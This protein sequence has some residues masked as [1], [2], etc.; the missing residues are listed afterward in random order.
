[1]PDGN[2]N[3]TEKQTCTD[4]AFLLKCVL[5]VNKE[6]QRRNYPLIEPIKFE[7]FEFI[8]YAIIATEEHEH[9]TQKLLIFDL[10]N[11]NI[12]YKI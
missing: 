12:K 2:N 5:E 6:Y 9:G 4:I 7:T 8:I 3:Y 11:K 10:I 1:M